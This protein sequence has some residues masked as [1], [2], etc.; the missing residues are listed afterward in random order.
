MADASVIDELVVRLRLDAEAYKKAEKQVDDQIGKT[1]T[2][3]KDRDVARKRRDEEQQKRWRALSTEA[4]AF[5]KSIGAVV[6]SVAALGAAVV[7]SLTSLNTFELGLRRQG[8]ST[9]L[10]NRELQ[11]WGS[12]ARRLGADANA[13][14]EAVANLAKE[15]KQFRITGEAPTLQALSRVGVRAS[16]DAPITDILADAQQ[17]Y[18]KA[19]PA[20]RD[21]MEASLSAQGVSPDLI[22]MITSTTDVLS[23]FSKSMTE[24]TDDQRKAQEELASALESAKNSAIS[25]SNT[26]LTALQPTIK[27]FGD[28]LSDAAKQTSEFTNKVIAAGGGLSGLS[29]V[30][31]KEYPPLGAALHGL[32]DVV[33][34]VR[35][36]LSQLAAVFKA[37]IG[38]GGWADRFNA[39]VQRE[40]KKTDHNPFW[41]AVNWAQGV[42][43]KIENVAKSTW[44]E[45]VANANAAGYN[46]LA[47]NPPAAT[48]APGQVA[49]SDAQALIGKLVQNGLTVPQA[50]AVVANWKGESNL[51]PASVNTEGGGTGA[52]G[53]A[54]WRGSR[55]EAFRTRYGITPDQASVDQQIQF[56]LTDPYERTLLAQS[57]AGGGGAQALGENYSRIYEA[58]GKQGED[59]LRGA[60]AVEL[61]NQYRFNNPTAAN[62]NGSTDSNGVTFNIQSM[63]VTANNPPELAN[64]VIR[65]SGVQNYNSAL[66]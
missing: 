41:G 26:L 34:V 44:G 6:L 65:N 29:S 38:S 5:T 58:H 15:Q 23:A 10:S 17:K 8:V 27:S 37:L 12:T 25:L 47:P 30:L 19:T 64:G 18:R 52:R 16:P 31:D 49:P 53:L 32:A 36:G 55:T 61:A 39:R 46:S 14:A 43:Q 48:P 54:N 4:K 21:Q 59:R 3:Q 33:D 7:G 2:K 24:A 50:A 66:R 1:E 22:L 28:W 40:I 60:R 13:G 42:G 56:M 20:Q 35:F 11:A 57:F 9:G 45:T 62:G 51:N 63:N